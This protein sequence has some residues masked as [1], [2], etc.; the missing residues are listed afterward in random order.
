MFTVNRV[1]YMLDEY[2]RTPLGNTSQID[3]ISNFEGMSYEIKDDGEVD[4]FAR[5][6]YDDETI[7][8]IQ[9]DRVKENVF[10]PNALHN[11]FVQMYQYVTNLGIT[12]RREAFVKLVGVERC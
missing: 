10:E 12:P 5:R 3:E 4:Q 7:H 8:F 9:L 1:V 2:E 11:S 6:F